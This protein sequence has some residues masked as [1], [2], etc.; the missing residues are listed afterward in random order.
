[1]K[2][3]HVKRNVQLGLEMLRI[4]LHCMQIK[5]FMRYISKLHLL[6]LGEKKIMILC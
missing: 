3:C 2:Q 5:E 1:M 6:K 4:F